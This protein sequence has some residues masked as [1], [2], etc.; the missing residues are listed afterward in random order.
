[1]KKLLFLFIV[2]FCLSITLSAQFIP[3]R[4]RS[5][6]QRS[7]EKKVEKEVEKKVVESIDEGT[8]EINEG[9]ENES[10]DGSKGKTRSS[11]LDDAIANR[12]MANMG[13]N[14]VKYEQSYAY[15]SKISMYI[16]TTVYNNDEKEVSTGHFNTYFDP[17]TLNYAVEIL[18]DD[19][20]DNDV[21]LI[22]FDKPNAVLL[23]LSE[24]NGEKSGMA[25]QMSVDSAS[26]EKQ[27]EVADQEELT[28]EQIDMMNLYY[29]ATGRTKNILGY[30]CREYKGVRS[31]SVEV[32]IWATRDIKIDYSN[33]YSYMGL[34]MLGGYGMDS[35][36]IGTT[37]E[38]HIIDPKTKK[39][40]DMYVREFDAKTN[41]TMN[42]S[43][44]QIIGFG[45]KK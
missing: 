34:G 38:M 2:S 37:M 36:L 4:V 44:Y 8:N 43:G 40:S 12:M 39:Q 18:S 23:I 27:T 6:I 9:N 1:M 15:T 19:K 10:S 24:E 31:D 17:S 3:S 33:A 14:N 28:D 13:M 45:D 26:T 20:N 22:I 5:S 29:K 25:M 21:G 30:K 16:E 35:Y 41:K 32:E 7:V 11:S 42:L